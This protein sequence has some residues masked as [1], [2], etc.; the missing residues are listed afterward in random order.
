M[1]V[2]CAQAASAP[3]LYFIFNSLGGSNSAEENERPRARSLPLQQLS[4]MTYTSQP[5][6]GLLLA[7]K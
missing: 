4:A 3:L 7:F 5:L 6:M 2:P 1:R